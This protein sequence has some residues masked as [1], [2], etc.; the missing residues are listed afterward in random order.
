MSNHLIENKQVLAT[1]PKGQD[2]QIRVSNIK[3]D[4]TEDDFEK[5]LVEN[6]VEWIEFEFELN[7]SEKFTGIAYATLDKANA[8][9]LVELNGHVDIL[10]YYIILFI[11]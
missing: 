11:L 3:Y 6:K 4:A 7:T 2:V 1:Y 10:L 8:E 5:F 9:K